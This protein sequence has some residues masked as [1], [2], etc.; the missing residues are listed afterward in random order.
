MNNFSVLH[1]PHN[2]TEQFC[3]GGGIHQQLAADLPDGAV[4]LLPARPAEQQPGGGAP[5]V[6]RQHHQ[7]Y[8]ATAAGQ[9]RIR[10]L[11]LKREINPPTQSNNTNFSEEKS[12]P[13]V[14]RNDVCL[15][16][17][18]NIEQNSHFCDSF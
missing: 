7:Q 5:R 11:Q 1:H 4:R 9:A 15:K 10:Q 14:C 16:K 13:K 17:K 12:K 3:L 18:F 6:S 2:G 8:P